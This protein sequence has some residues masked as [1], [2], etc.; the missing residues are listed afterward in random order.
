MD[1][2]RDALEA[3]HLVCRW[4]E[5]RK[6]G[7]SLSAD[8][9]DRKRNEDGFYQS[10]LASTV[11]PRSNETTKRA[12]AVLCVL[13]QSSLPRRQSERT[14]RKKKESETSVDYAPLAMYTCFSFLVRSN[15]MCQGEAVARS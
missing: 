1:A 13:G 6:G 14:R 15:A 10:R 11:G 2:D 9:E 3:G 4:L 7:S 8:V 5:S 12:E